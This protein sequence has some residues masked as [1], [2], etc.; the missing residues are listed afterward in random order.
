M[1]V[2]DPRVVAVQHVAGIQF[3]RPKSGKDLNGEGC[4]RGLESLCD[5]SARRARGF[6]TA[7]TEP[8]HRPESRP[9]RD[10]GNL[11]RRTS[12]ADDALLG[13]VGSSSGGQLHAPTSRIL[14]LT[15]HLHS[16]SMGKL[17][18]MQSFIR[19]LSPLPFNNA[20]FFCCTEKYIPENITPEYLSTN[21]S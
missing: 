11:L 4:V 8:G 15:S 1:Y 10:R 17:P 6:R 21:P 13:G 18:P 19:R 20:L 5:E 2:D 16:Y 12:M 3:L 9:V 7:P 14:H